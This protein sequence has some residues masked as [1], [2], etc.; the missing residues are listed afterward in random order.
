[1]KL[2]STGFLLIFI[3]LVGISCLIFFSDQI[4]HT[5]SSKNRAPF[6]TIISSIEADLSQQGNK[7]KILKI[8]SEEGLSIE[9]YDSNSNYNKIAEFSLFNKYDGHIMIEGKATNLALKDLD[10]DQV[11]EIIAPSFSKNQEPRVHIF[12]FNLPLLTFE[13]ITHLDLPIG[14]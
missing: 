5:I 14:S 11:T 2:K 12:K 6:R 3:G 1:M 13:E 8:K 7:Y 10:G 9:I 4:R